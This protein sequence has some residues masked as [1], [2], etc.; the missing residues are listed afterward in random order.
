MRTWLEIGVEQLVQSS[1]YQWAQTGMHY[2]DVA[3]SGSLQGTPAIAKGN[4]G[5]CWQKQL[6]PAPVSTRQWSAKGE[7]AAG[8]CKHGN[9]CGQC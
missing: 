5:C 2:R 7:K 9:I 1:L 6:L 4:C 3:Q 8:H